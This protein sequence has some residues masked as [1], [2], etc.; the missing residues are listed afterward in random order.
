MSLEYS[1]Y[2]ED[3]YFEEGSNIKDLLNDMDQF[4]YSGNLSGKS[5]EHDEFNEVMMQKKNENKNEKEENIPKMDEKNKFDMVITSYDESS[6][7]KEV[8]T[9]GVEEKSNTFLSE[10][11]KTVKEKTILNGNICSDDNL[12]RK[13]KHLI[14]NSL[15]IFINNKIKEL[16]NNRIGRGICIKQLQALNQKTKST[17]NINYNKELIIKTIGEIFSDKISG[18]FSNFMPDHNQRLIQKLL[19]EE[20]IDIRNYFTQIFNLTFFQCLEHYRGTKNYSEL[21]EMKVFAD[22]IKDFG[23]EENY[24]INLQYY[25][26][27]FENIINNKRSRKS[28][29]MLMKEK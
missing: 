18:R 17:P 5:T 13:C 2:N 1:G 20:N 15:L 14:L 8:D 27:N 10:N 7:K 9:V 11:T 21:K 4:E 24:I 12:R 28:K 23:E 26:N 16:Y 25:L 19:N 29:K 22:D 3:E 6:N